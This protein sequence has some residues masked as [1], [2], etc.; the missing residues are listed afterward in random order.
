M[1]DAKKILIWVCG[2]RMR[3]KTLLKYMFDLIN[4]FR[5]PF[6]NVADTLRNG[7]HLLIFFPHPFRRIA[8]RLR[9]RIYK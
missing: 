9:L 4:P 6:R 2:L 7:V 5:N 3:P 1:L 8:E